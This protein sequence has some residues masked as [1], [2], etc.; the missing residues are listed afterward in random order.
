[1]HLQVH[2]PTTTVRERMEKKLIEM[3]CYIIILS[4]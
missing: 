1:M 3:L 2:I 4:A